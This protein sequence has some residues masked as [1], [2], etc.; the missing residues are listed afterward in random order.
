VAEKDDT[1]GV[2]ILSQFAGAS[3]ELGDALIVNPYDIEQMADSIKTA[4]EMPVS[5]QKSRMK[6]LR[7]EVENNNIYR[8]SSEIIKAMMAIKT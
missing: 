3:R 4:L 6:R 8:W 2:L 5:E 7:S 1:T